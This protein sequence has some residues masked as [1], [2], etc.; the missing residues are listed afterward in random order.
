MKIKDEMQIDSLVKIERRILALYK[1]LMG[2]EISGKLESHE[3]DDIAKLISELEVEEDNELKNVTI[4][5]LDFMDNLIRHENDAY[6]I[7]KRIRNKV[8]KRILDHASNVRDDDDYFDNIDIRLGEEIDKRR[9][10]GINDLIDNEKDPEI[11]ELLISSKYKNLYKAILLEPISDASKITELK[12]NGY[13]RGDIISVLKDRISFLINDNLIV[14]VFVDDKSL[15]EDKEMQR[16][17]LL[18]L[19]D[20]KIGLDL[21]NKND[22]NSVYEYLYDNYL[23][24]HSTIALDYAKNVLDSENEIKNKVKNKTRNNS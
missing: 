1:K 20:L 5:C 24:S 17:V 22:F 14:V 21:M 2:L 3:Y 11:K 18:S 23:S 15:K 4:G 8:F 13:N 16:D 12:L 7:G 19:N 6:L 9:I 10:Y